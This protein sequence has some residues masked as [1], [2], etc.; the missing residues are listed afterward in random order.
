MGFRKLK[1]AAIGKI[2]ERMVVE[3]DTKPNIANKIDDY[4]NAK[5]AF[6]TTSGVHLK[7][8]KPF[9]VKGDHT[10]RV[11]PGDVDFDDLTITHDHYDKSSALLDKNIVFPLE[12]L[13]DLQEEGVISSVAPRNFGIMGYIPRVDKYREIS[14]VEIADMLEEDGVDIVLLSPGWYICHQSVG[15]V[16]REIESRGI[17][18]ASISHLQNVISRTRPPRV[19]NIDK[20]LG[21]TFGEVGEVDRQKDLLVQLLDLAAEGGEEEYRDAK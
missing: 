7:E 2:A 3:L 11:I 10:Y 9:N 15:L 8:D 6:V 13:R 18:T 4:K 17:R 21:H 1:Q 5:V 14:I 12:R 20:E 16:Q 19:L